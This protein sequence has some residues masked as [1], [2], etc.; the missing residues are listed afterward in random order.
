M[1]HTPGPWKI[2][3]IGE[4]SPSKP[5]K[6][7]G[8]RKDVANGNWSNVAY[9]LEAYTKNSTWQKPIISEESQAN[10]KLITAAPE[11]RYKMD[12]K[13]EVELLKIVRLIET[14]TK[15]ISELLE[16]TQKIIDTQKILIEE[17]EE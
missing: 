7:V 1:K 5:F 6:V 16:I 11:R 12:N 9:V 13:I 10:A 2:D 3:G 8:L 17:K 4:S 15:H 14:N